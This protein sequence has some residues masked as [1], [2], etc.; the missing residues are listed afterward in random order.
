MWNTSSN[1]VPALHTDHWVILFPV[2]IITV[3]D[4]GY[5][6]YHFLLVFILEDFTFKRISYSKWYLTNLGMGKVSKIYWYGILTLFA[7]PQVPSDNESTI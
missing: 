2:F 5:L 4:T 7:D 1:S 6:N 3:R